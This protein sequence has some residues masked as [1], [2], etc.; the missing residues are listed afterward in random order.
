MRLLLVEDEEPVAQTIRSKL[1]IDYVIDWAP[2]GQKARQY[3]M[4]SDYNLL[5]YDYLLPDTDGASL[6]SYTRNQSIKTPILMLT[7]RDKVID[8]VLALD[9]GADD[10]LTKPFSFAELSAR[11]R[12]LT[13]R[14]KCQTHTKTQLCLDNLQIDI[15][16]RHVLLAGQPIHLR[17]KEYDIL[18]LLMQNQGRAF[19][20]DQILEQIW[21]CPWEHNSNIVDV[22]INY[23]RRLIDKPF[24]R[25]LVQTVPGVGYKIDQP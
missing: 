4:A 2:N 25:K 17:R 22:H 10:Y 16:I 20:R 5:V 1:K 7:G 19:S 18:V 9:A 14:P 8:K 12:A 23:L 11:L 6:C 13:R 24:K 3:L 15:S 21:A